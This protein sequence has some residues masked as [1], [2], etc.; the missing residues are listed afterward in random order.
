MAIYALGDQVPTISGDA[1]VH[2][3][4]TIIGSVTIGSESSVWPGAVVRGDGGEIVIGD[5]TSVQDNAVLHTTPMWPTIVGSDCVLGHLIH[6]EGCTIE[7]HV[8]V[9]NA[10]MVLH[11]CVVR[12][13]SI[14]AANAVVLN[15]TEV[16]SGAIAVG[17]PAVIKEGRARRA[18]I[19]LG[20]QEYVRRAAQYRSE[21]RRLD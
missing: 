18:D 13:G 19:D 4:A 6:L 12:T 11:R 20:S 16:P 21:L 5:R 10:S 2:P 1:F 9:G 17:T 7:D 8:L 14:V 15:G 3:D